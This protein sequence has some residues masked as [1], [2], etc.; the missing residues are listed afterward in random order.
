MAQVI[1]TNPAFIGLGIEE[2]TAIIVRN[3]L[4]EK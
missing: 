4:K 1:M 2:D 3:G